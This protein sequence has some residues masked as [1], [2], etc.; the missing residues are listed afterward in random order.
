MKKIRLIETDTGSRVYLQ[1]GK[2]LEFTADQKGSDGNEAN[3]FNVYDEVEYQEILGFGGAFTEASALN[4]KGLT[5]EQK[6]EVSEKYFSVEN[7]IGY[8]FCR[9]TINSCDFSADF[10]SYDDVEGDFDLKHFDIA[11]DKDAIIPMI[12]AAAE[13]SPEMKIFSSPWS[14]PAWMKTNGKMAKGGS[15]KKECYDVWARYVAKYIQ[16]YEKAGV[17]IWGV[18]VQNESK[19]AQGWESCTYEAGEERDLVL[20]YMRPYFERMGL[21]RKSV[22]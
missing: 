19:A 4:F 10:Y 18:T 20:G 16:E 7:G 6:K 3:I 17:R 11:H 8:N 12:K 14:P 21:D 15:L 5:E 2:P 1:E 13:L 9:A 22:V